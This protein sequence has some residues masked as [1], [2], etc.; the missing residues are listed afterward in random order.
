MRTGR[1]VK[2]D[3]IYKMQIHVNGTHRYASTQPFTVGEDGKK[4]YTHKH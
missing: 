4:R 3:T 2:A 1:P